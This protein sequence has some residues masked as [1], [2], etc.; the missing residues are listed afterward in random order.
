MLVFNGSPR[1]LGRAHGEALRAQIHEVTSWYQERWWALSDEQLQQQVAPFIVTIKQRSPHLAQEI[2]GIAQGAAQPAWRI[3]A[4]N[5]RTELGPSLEV[6]ECTSVGVRAARAHGDGIV[7]AQNWDWWSGLRGL[8]RLVKLEPTAG[9]RILTLIEPGML[10]KIGL[11]EDGLGLCLNALHTRA[12]NPSGLPIHL[13]CRLILECRSWS[14]ARAMLLGGPHAASAYYLV[15]DAQDQLVGVECTPA[16]SFELATQDYLAHANTHLHD[17]APCLRQ[18]IFERRLDMI[19][20]ELTREHIKDAL[21]HPGV[22][23]TPDEASGVES[24][25]TIVMELKARRLE[26]SDGSRGGPYQTFEL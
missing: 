4:L 25:H 6:L 7:L 17:H 18:R 10:G 26:L 14:Q 11:N 21:R 5:S 15:G 1:A 20:G 2:E 8:T 23:A 12:I 13:R 22:E 3:Y 16:S 24:L 9:P 19:S